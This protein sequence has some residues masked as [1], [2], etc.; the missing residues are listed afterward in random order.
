MNNHDRDLAEE[1]SDRIFEQPKLMTIDAWVGIG[2]VLVSFFA[3][4]VTMMFLEALR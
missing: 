1:Q 3:G 4:V 2:L